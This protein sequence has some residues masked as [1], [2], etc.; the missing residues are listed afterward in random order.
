MIRTG[1]RVANIAVAVAAAAVVIAAVF[2][3]VVI[4]GYRP[5]TGPDVEGTGS[6]TDAQAE[7]T[8][9]GDDDPADGESYNLLC[10]GRDPTSGLC[11]TVV[12][13]RIDPDG[14]L[15]AMQLPR[16]TYVRVNG[17]GRKLNS[18]FSLLGVSGPGSARELL[19]ASLCVRIDYVVEISTAAFRAAVDALG[20]VVVDV[21]RDMDYEDPYQDLYIHIKAGRQLL[22]GEH[23]EQFVRYRKGYSDGDLGRLDAQKIFLK[24]LASTVRENLTIEAAASIINEV[25]PLVKTDMNA[26]DALFFA[27][28]ILTG[29]SK[30]TTLLTAPGRALNSSKYGLS[31]YV[32]GRSAALEAVNEYFNVYPSDIPDASFDRDEIFVEKGDDEF[33]RIYRYAIITP[34]T[35][36]S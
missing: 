13:L 1:S 18:A 15:C 31:F 4:S 23:A 35:G 14:G 17:E 5:A 29:G 6:E 21:P 36:N 3:A 12:L 10:V 20:G 22:D 28:R 16:D 19:S 26:A 11:D 33:E 9:A 8:T 34:D 2:A 30:Q 27:K 25:L 7:I 32:L 24:A